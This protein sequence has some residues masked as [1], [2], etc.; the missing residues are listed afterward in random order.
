MSSTKTVT[1]LH[2][3]EALVISLPQ[4]SDRLQR[5]AQRLHGNGGWPFPTPTVM[6]GVRETSPAWYQSSDGAW[7]CR[8]AHLKILHSQWRR[9]IQSTLVLE[10]DA[11]WGTNVTE[12]WNLISEKIPDDWDMVMLGGE[13][14]SAPAL[15][16]TH[17]VRCINTRR[18]HAYLIRL[19]AIPLL[20]RTWQQARHHIDHSSRAFQQQARVYA[21]D[22]FLF[23]QDRG[24]S[25]IFGNEN[26]D[27]RYWS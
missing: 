21:T 25:D 1:G 6:D 14:I 13:H 5:F 19:K 23:G 22:P 8:Q 15:I 20:I 24:R 26:E 9:G 7:G 4:R 2:I 11:I 3:D 16:D 12:R 10:D 17:V 18:T 27:V